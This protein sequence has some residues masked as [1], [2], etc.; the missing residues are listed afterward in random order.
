[1]STN[2]R[3]SSHDAPTQLTLE[4]SG[5]TQ[6]FTSGETTAALASASSVSKGMPSSGV[7]RCARLRPPSFL[8]PFKRSPNTVMP[9]PSTRSSAALTV[10]PSTR[11]APLAGLLSA[12][13]PTMLPFEQTAQRGLARRQR[14]FERVRSLV[15]SSDLI[16]NANRRA[17]RCRRR[18]SCRPA[19]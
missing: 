14:R 18:A 8:K 12:A 11:S 5:P 2:V 10:K 1:M 4:L 7:D 19:A 16:Q 13:P 17:I 15:L 6:L 3:P 9:R